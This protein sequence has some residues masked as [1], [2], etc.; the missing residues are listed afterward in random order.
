MIKSSF[1]LVIIFA[2]LIIIGGCTTTVEQEE[3]SDEEA[4]EEIEEKEQGN[5]DSKEFDSGEGESGED[6]STSKDQQTEDN[7]S[8]QE[9]KALYKVNETNW[10]VE[11]LTESEQNIVLLTI[12]DALDKYSADMA[13]A[14]NELG[15]GA[16]FFVNGHFIESEK[17][18]ADLKKIHDMGFEIGNHTMNHPNLEELSEEEQYREIVELNDLI[19]E[20]TG[21]RPRFFR[22]PFGAN[23]A[24]SE[25]VVRDEG[26]IL[27]N[28]TYGY[29]WE[30]EYMEKEALADIMVNTPL[31]TNGA[32]ILMHDREWTMEAIEDIVTGL[33]EKGYDIVDPREIKGL[34]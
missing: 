31:L 22:A 33:K 20:V 12:D 21:E 11:S 5:S 24:Y 10:K 30:A 14:L 3:I 28:W 2:V 4:V 18:Q 9:P 32:N 23:T 29:D 17:G 19:E 7:I 26:M 6:E 27:M 1:Y 15:A 8:E 16:I 25:S 13:D 34:Q